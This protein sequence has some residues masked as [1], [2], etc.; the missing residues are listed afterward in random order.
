MFNEVD[1]FES[2]FTLSEPYK[3]NWSV[4]SPT[5]DVMTDNTQIME[6]PDITA[7]Q[8]GLGVFIRTSKLNWDAIKLAFQSEIEPQCYEP[9]QQAKF[10]QNDGIRQA[11][12]FIFE[13]VT[14]HHVLRFMPQQPPLWR[15][16]LQP[17]IQVIFFTLLW[18]LF[19]SGIPFHFL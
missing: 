1:P 12:P 15:H 19:W 16:S 3:K 8:C 9:N 6:M 5:G 2:V 11:R 10:P 4:C 18:L 7:T 17:F 13:I 14:F